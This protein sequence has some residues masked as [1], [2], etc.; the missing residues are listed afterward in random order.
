ML[1]K[2]TVADCRAQIAQWKEGGL[3][4]EELDIEELHSN[5]NWN[6]SETWL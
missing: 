6:A 4:R 3:R 5:L 2:I 1:R